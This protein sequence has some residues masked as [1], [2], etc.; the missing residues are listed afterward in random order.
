MIRSL[1]GWLRVVWPPWFSLVLAV[2][3]MAGFQ[4]IFLWLE[5]ITREPFFSM[6]DLD[7]KRVWMALLVLYGAA[8]A[9]YRVIAFHPA[10]RPE[11]H[12]WLSATPW[13]SQRPL[14]LGPVHLVLQDVILVAIA[15][16]LGW[17]RLQWDALVLVVGFLMTYLV[18]L[19]A[20][21]AATGA[22]GWAYAIG[23]GI[24]LMMLYVRDPLVVVGAAAMTYGF[25]YL[26][27]RAALAGF[28]WEQHN[29]GAHLKK[30]QGPPA[31]RNSGLGWP[32]DHMSPCT[33]KVSGIALRDALLLGGLAGW[34]FFAISYQLRY[35]VG[36][37]GGRYTVLCGA[38]AV[39]VVG[40]IMVYCVC[41][42]PPINLAGRLAHGRLII[43]GYDQVFV[44][45][46]LTILVGLVAWLVPAVTGVDS[47]LVT[48][49]AFALVWWVI[50]GMGPSLRT[51]RLSGNHRISPGIP[52][53]LYAR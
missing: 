22:R 12:T 32:F 5:W 17:P 41:Y 16:V 43:P 15:C 10:L 45:P 11:Y 48:P 52:S 8:Y 18:A 37:V 23:F 19:G 6:H 34:W 3:I 36:A 28:P 29:F 49:L 24:G 51:W 53:G 2:I 26:G 27:L 4:A 1:C 14:P 46:L 40:R 13:T 33:K 30:Y 21:H 39:A 50:L 9:L 35:T 25:A 42:V 31:A 47:L 20:L 7:A 44:A 38:I